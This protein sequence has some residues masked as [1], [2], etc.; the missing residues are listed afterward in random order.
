MYQSLAALSTK[1]PRQAAWVHRRSHVQVIILVINWL[2]VLSALARPQWLEEPLAI[3]QQRRDLLVLVDISGS[4]NERDQTNQTRLEQVKKV[5]QTFA[6]QRQ[7]DRLGL[8]VFADKPYMQAPITGDNDVW[9]QL[10]FATRVGPAGRNTAMG[11]AIGLG[12]KHLQDS[13]NQEKVMLVLTDGSDNRSLVPPREAAIVAAQ[14]D[15]QIFTVAIG[16]DTENADIDTETLREVAEISGGQF[17]DA[18]SAEALA[19]LATDFA[20]AVPSEYSV[21]WYYPARELYVYPMFII[22]TFSMGVA[23]VSF[24]RQRRGGR[25]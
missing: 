10:L 16:D 13:A 5:L 25:L 20:E 1:R 3:E 22:F 9:R 19:T 6:T 7:G 12:L 21:A 4:M 15:V 14:R 11:D 17:Y 2:L 8:I 24:I 18:R 23:L